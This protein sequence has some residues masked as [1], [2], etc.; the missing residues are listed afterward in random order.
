MVKKFIL[1]ISLILFSVHQVCGQEGFHFDTHKNKISIP[2][3]FINNLI[4]IPVTV[5]GVSMNFLLDTGVEDTILFSIDDTDEV[6]F[7]QLEKIKIRGLGSNEAFFGY[8][9]VHNN[10]VIN[11]YADTNHDIYLV[12]DQNINISAQVGFPVNGILG[13]QFF[14]NHLVKINYTSNRIIIYRNSAKG[15]KRL[16]KSYI[17]LPL[18][19]I[20]N[21]P[22]I[23]GQSFFEDQQN[24]LCS[25]LL[26]DTGNCDA[27]W[28]FRQNNERIAIP[29]KSI[30]DFLGS[31]F[32]GEIYGRR[33]KIKALE[34][35]QFKFLYPIAAF[36][37]TIA[38]T[39]LDKSSGR[40]GSIGSEIMRRFTVVLD[41]KSE[42]VYL[43]KNHHFDDP[44]H[45]NM[46][47]LEI[48]HKGLQWISSSYEDNPTIGNNLFRSSGEKIINNLKY[49]FDLKPI[50]VITNIRKNAPAALAGLQKEDVLVTIDKKNAFNFTLQ[51]INAL[52]KSEE[53]KLIEIEIERNGTIL[54]FKFK[55]EEVY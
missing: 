36:P 47:G 48:Q 2:F 40:I 54:Q 19:F 21:K 50:Y 1:L 34:I 41:Y 35:G 23:V 15:L 17:K 18:E 22:F 45:F 26:L 9:S 44:F 51:E 52:L 42:A 25:K 43:K 46:S 20:N 32:S 10:L 14:K 39:N 27:L 11:D 3:Q 31:G 37:D 8:K 24:A 55:L 16:P 33:G 28:Y 29:K 7:S 12:L 4:I 6:S 13:Y 38:T 53:G 30:E 49:R 5:N